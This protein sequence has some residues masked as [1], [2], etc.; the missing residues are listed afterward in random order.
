M[1]VAHRA[2]SLDIVA[3]RGMVDRKSAI[4]RMSNEQATQGMDAQLSRN[5]SSNVVVSMSGLSI[6]RYPG[7]AKSKRPSA[8]ATSGASFR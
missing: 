7:M 4:G 3:V 5:H 2:C 8:V 1:T 6:L